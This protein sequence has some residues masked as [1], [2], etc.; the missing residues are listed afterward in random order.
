MP[1]VSETRF[2]KITERGLV[3]T[4]TSLLVTEFF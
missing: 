1:Q 3:A 4:L 2:P